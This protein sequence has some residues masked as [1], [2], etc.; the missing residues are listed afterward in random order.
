MK[1]KTLHAG[2]SK[3][4]QC[5]RNLPHLENMEANRRTAPA[6]LCLA[7][8]LEGKAACNWFM[9][10]SIASDLPF[11]TRPPHQKICADNSAESILMQPVMNDKVAYA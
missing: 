9:Q 6:L 3:K 10:S 5:A 2:G 1:L 8:P 4:I 11:G 7:L